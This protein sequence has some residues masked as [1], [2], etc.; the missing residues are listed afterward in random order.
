MSYYKQWTGVTSS[1]FFTLIDKTKLIVNFDLVVNISGSLRFIS[2]SAYL[3][4]ILVVSMKYTRVASVPVRRGRRR[5]CTAAR[6]WSW[7]AGVSEPALPR[8][9]PHRWHWLDSAN[10]QQDCQSFIKHKNSNII[11]H[12]YN[13]TLK[14]GDGML[15]HL[16]HLR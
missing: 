16:Q 4:I 1:G 3:D 14:N 15:Y 2:L 12:A 7:V 5:G 10:T 6:D 8:H 9:S 11:I 13:K